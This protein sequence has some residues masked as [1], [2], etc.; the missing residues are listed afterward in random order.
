MESADGGGSTSGSSSLLDDASAFEDMA[1]SLVRKSSSPSVSSPIEMSLAESP[2]S[3]VKSVGAA[4]L[5]FGARRREK[6]IPAEKDIEVDPSPLLDPSPE[7]P[8]FDASF[9]S[10]AGTYTEE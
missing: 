10:I 9:S 2:L 6:N 5:G 3:S 4:L 8:A 1:D 7:G